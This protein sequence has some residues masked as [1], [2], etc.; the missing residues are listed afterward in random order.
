MYKNLNCF[1]K[2][3]RSLEC[4]IDYDF[5]NES[6][7]SRIRNQKDSITKFLMYKEYNKSDGEFDC[8]NSNGTCPLTDD[9]YKELWGWSYETR[10][11]LKDILK[12]KFGEVWSRF[13]ADTMNSY[14]TTYTR[15]KKIYGEDELRKNKLLCEF[16]RYTH[17]IGNFTLIPFSIDENTPFNPYRNAEF[18][19]YFDI[20]LKFIK[21]KI[22]AK[23]F[24]EYIDNFYLNDYVD[25]NYNILPLMSSHKE[26]LQQEEMHIDDADM[27]LPQNKQELNEYLENVIDKI[28]SRGKRIAIL[29]TEKYSESFKIPSSNKGKNVKDMKNRLLAFLKSKF[30]KILIGFICTFVLLFIGLSVLNTTTALKMSGDFSAILEKYG[31]FISLGAILTKCV[32]V[33]ISPAFGLTIGVFVVAFIIWLAYLGFANTFL[34]RCRKCKNLF[35]VKKINSK[36]IDERVKYFTVENKIRD[37]DGRFTGETTEQKL[38]GKVITRKIHYKCKF[39]GSYFYKIKTFEER[40]DVD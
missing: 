28:K 10:F 5:K 12:I 26:L 29:L 34:R 21:E 1:V 13:S 2:N 25:N 17:T 6:P 14:Q 40:P 32:L 24:K 16:A 8:D 3:A 18:K 30:G 39:C 22:D 20:S 7:C 9:I 11:E 35:A 4:I 36:I 27:L 31:I 15:A 38:P 19:D 33:S 23:T 37:Y